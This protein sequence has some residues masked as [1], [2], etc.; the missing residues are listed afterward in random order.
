MLD[1][2]TRRVL[3]W[4][5]SITMEAAFCVETLED[6]LERHVN[7]ET[8]NTDQSSQFTGAAFTG[9][10]A[11]NSIANSMDGKGAWRDNVFVE[12][13]IC[14]PTRPSARR[15]ARLVGSRLLQCRPSA[16]EPSRPHPDQA[17]LDLPPLRAA[18]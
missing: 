2:A 12:R 13:S 11:D 6:A 1:W 17:Y 8:F 9:V 15:E 14:A 4:R 16:F 10:L 3:S 18:A 5:V 7:P